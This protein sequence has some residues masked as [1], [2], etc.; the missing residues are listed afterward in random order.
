MLP[1]HIPLLHSH[2]RTEIGGT[3]DLSKQ[4][5]VPLSILWGV[6]V[7]VSLAP[8]EHYLTRVKYVRKTR[9]SGGR[10]KTR[11]SLSLRRKSLS[12]SLRRNSLRKMTKSKLF[13]VKQ[14][15]SLFKSGNQK[16]PS[17]ISRTVFN[18]QKLN[19]PRRFP[20]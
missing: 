3:F 16:Q 1:G 7:G 17:R 14:P 13:K 10:A 11:R 2:H 20:N 19:G 6:G 12:T 18:A 4:E 5:R 15:T 8:E 9:S